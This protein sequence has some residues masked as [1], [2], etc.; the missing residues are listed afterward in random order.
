MIRKNKCFK[1]I[2]IIV[3]IICFFICFIG[4][5][6]NARVPIEKSLKSNG[7]I[8][9]YNDDKIEFVK[10]KKKLPKNKQ[11]IDYIEPNWTYK[12][13]IIP[14][15]THF[16]KQW[17]LNKIKAVETWD[18]VRES[19][20]IV[21]AVIDS[22]VW[23]DHPDLSGNIWKNNDE[24]P[25]NN[26][27]D[28][29]NGFI[30]DINGW[31]FVNKINDPNP[32]F[33]QGFSREGIL[34]GTVIAGVMAGYGN[35]GIGISGVTW[36][37][38][39]MPLKVLDD[40]GEGDTLNVV[41][42]IDYAIANKANIINFS[43]IGFGYSKTLEEAIERAYRAGIVIV[44]AAGN[45]PGNGDG[46]NLD[47]TPMYPAC[48]DGNNGENMIIGV[49]ATDAIDQKASFS[50]YGFKCIDITAPGVS[51]YST[52]IYSP[53]NN[54]DNILFNNYYEG[55]WS[56]TSM[57]TPIVS[58]AVALLK[59]VNPR[60]SNKKLIDIIISGADNISRLNPKH[61]GQLGSGRLNILNSVNE[62]KLTMFSGSIKII[63]AL[64]SNYKS[65]IKITNIDGIEENRFFVFNKNFNGGVN[66]VS[67]DLNSDGIDEI[68]TGAG[69]GGGPHVRIF[70]VNGKVKSQFFAY[71]KNFRGGVNVFVANIFSN[72]NSMKKEIICAPEFGGGPH[73]R[74]FNKDGN[75]L[76][77]FFA[78]N[79]NFRGGV[80]ISA[81]DINYDGFDEIITGAG[82]GGSPHVRIFK[83]DGKL[84]KSFYAFD[85]K[86]N[87][88]INVGF[89]KIK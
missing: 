11:N 26:I 81:V 57:A 9:K 19:P 13:S 7:F 63:S 35:N 18:Q 72:V 52:S 32:K 36:Q 50:S 58:G 41:R 70:D 45:D 66:L 89:I 83:K 53:Q 15:D 86:L 22:G 14:S 65:I 73:I 76:S 1:E 87:G 46:Y 6:C 38:K 78:Y 51:I 61:L 30:D 77:Q 85:E 74:I 42:A 68:I 24:I 75:I 3:F 25:N 17:Y 5:N 29:K 27:D 88:G 21:I 80:N 54:R 48:Y 82:F 84:L 31:D 71:D 34:H 8:V 55:Y 79:K 16:D 40:N 59:I 43:F 4:I 37:A 62:A 28:D 49:A 56:G 20:E 64:Q 67:G 10:N 69:N 47:T 39:I 44:A 2:F 12:M 23:I 60:L 33:N